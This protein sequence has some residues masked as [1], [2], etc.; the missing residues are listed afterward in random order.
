MTYTKPFSGEVCEWNPSVDNFVLTYWGIAL[1]TAHP[2]NKTFSF[3]SGL[4]GAIRANNIRLSGGKIQ[5]LSAKQKVIILSQF[6]DPLEVFKRKK[7]K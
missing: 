7:V 2:S 6:E 4:C 3:G 5:S 1:P